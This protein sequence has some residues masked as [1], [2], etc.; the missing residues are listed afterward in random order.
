MLGL[1]L[2]GLASHMTRQR[3]LEI[4]IRKVMGASVAKII[5]LLSKETTSMILLSFAI[6]VPVV[7]IYGSQ[8]LDNF[9]YRINMPWLTILISGG[10][11]LVIA[12]IS[13]AYSVSAAARANPVETLKSD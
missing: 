4:G 5:L 11:A 13:I 10:L 9:F 2:V 1:G 3:S 12:W 6:A 7:W 8:W